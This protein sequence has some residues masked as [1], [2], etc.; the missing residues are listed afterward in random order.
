MWVKI[1]RGLDG[2]MKSPRWGFSERRGGRKLKSPR[3]QGA[4][5]LVR[6][7]KTRGKARKE[8]GGYQGGNLFNGDDTP[9]HIEGGRVASE[10]CEQDRDR[11]DGAGVKE[12]WNNRAKL[13]SHVLPYMAEGKN[14]RVIMDE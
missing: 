5:S 11:Q 4:E 12:Y 1:Q 6:E 7:G 13:E 2:D 3:D 14:C 8:K 9:S 10:V